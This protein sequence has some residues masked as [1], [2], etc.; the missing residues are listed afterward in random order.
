M[1]IKSPTTL[2]FMNLLCGE[3]FVA[4]NISEHFLK[5][6]I[7]KHLKKREL[8]FDLN[9]KKRLIVYHKYSVKQEVYCYRKQFHDLITFNKIKDTYKDRDQ[10]YNIK[11]ILKN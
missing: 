1:H 10:H 8:G 7:L 2:Y 11:G 9:E 4:S 6:H 3:A 5:V